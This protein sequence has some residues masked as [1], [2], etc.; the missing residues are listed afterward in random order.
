M[1]QPYVLENP[2]VVIDHE[3]YG[4]KKV[5]EHFKLF[6][7]ELIGRQRGKEEW[8]RLLYFKEGTFQGFYRDLKM[9]KPSDANAYLN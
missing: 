6:Y 9:V 3:Y 7:Q 5:R 1:K 2:I 4:T 8:G